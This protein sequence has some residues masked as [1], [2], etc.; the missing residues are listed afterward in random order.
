MAASK[1][2]ISNISQTTSCR[3]MILGSK[4]IFSW[5]RNQ[6][7]TLYS[8]ADHYYVCKRTKNMIKNP[9]KNSNR[10]KMNMIGAC[11]ILYNDV[12]DEKAAKRMT[13]ANSNINDKSKSP[14]SNRFLKFTLS[15]LARNQIQQF[16]N[17]TL[18]NVQDNI[19]DIEISSN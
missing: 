10:D 9:I 17:I 14:P 8:M 7:N 13:I 11:L 4:P 18:L 15:L 16:L 19:C 2:E 1:S 5:S 3:I 6:I 12:K